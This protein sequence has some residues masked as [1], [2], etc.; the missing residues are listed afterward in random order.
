MVSD[1]VEQCCGHLG[2]A[3]ITDPFAE[4]PVGGDDQRGLFV[5]L[6]DQV[7]QQRPTG[8]RKG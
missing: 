1:A 2:V 5:E 4:G 6:A 7:K 3:K 8:V